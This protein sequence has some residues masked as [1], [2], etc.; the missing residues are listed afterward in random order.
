MFQYIFPHCKQRILPVLLLLF[1]LHPPV[2]AQVTNTGFADS[3]AGIVIG[4]GQLVL[5]AQL[6][7]YYSMAQPGYTRVPQLVSSATLNQWDVN[8]AL[9]DLRYRG[10]SVRSRITP[11]Y[12]SYLRRNYT[13]EEPHLLEASLGVKPLKN[14]NLWVDVGILGSPFTNESPIS[15]DQ[16]TYTRSLSAEFV[17]YY[18]C[19]IR[20][21]YEWN[22]RLNTYLYLVNGWQQIND[23]VVGQGLIAQFEYR[24]TPTLL[25]N[26]NYFRSREQH[27]SRFTPTSGA[28]ATDTRDLIDFYAIYRSRKGRLI[29]ASLYRGIQAGDVWTQANL[30]AEIPIAPTVA[31]S[32]RVEQLND[33]AGVVVGREQPGK[34]PRLR[35]YS[36]GL[37]WQV[38]NKILWRLEYRR[39]SGLFEV[40]PGKPFS[41]LT[42]HAGIVL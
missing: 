28:S 10:G 4:N 2:L 11:G 41:Y 15:R 8:L 7:L 26:F 40:Q 35:G 12:G 34:S 31:A 25:L 32:V 24:P 16:L 18:L 6:D 29:T 39:L 33:P 9:L 1:A 3:T 27:A 13:P 38:S 19:G 5:G 36:S 14:K 37:K 22:A 23:R 17:P 30:I 20:L 42:L 21:G